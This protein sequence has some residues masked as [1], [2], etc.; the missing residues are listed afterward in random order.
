MI[1]GKGFAIARAR[2]TGLER[3]A[4]DRLPGIWPV[5]TQGLFGLAPLKP[6]K[7]IRP[8]GCDSGPGG[9]F[10]VPATSLAQQGMDLGIAVCGQVEPTMTGGRVQD[11]AFAVA[12][13][14]LRWPP[15][16]AGMR[17]ELLAAKGSLLALMLGLSLNDG[18]KSSLIGDVAA[19]AVEVGPLPVR[20]G[21]GEA[22]T[23]AEV[24]P[25]VSRGDHG[26]GGIADPGD[27]HAI[28]TATEFW[29]RERGGVA[30]RNSRVH[31]TSASTASM[32][33]PFSAAVSH[34]WVLI[35]PMLLR[36]PR[37]MT[38]APPPNA[39]N[40]GREQVWA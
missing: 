5:V 30:G 38:C 20:Q 35:Q 24:M 33:S 27:G 7:K 16:R 29:D 9:I 19:M 13:R 28:G 37:S 18:V 10:L 23:A 21:F 12:D 34:S 25:P 4:M 40:R 22:P 2:F 8:S 32:S 14:A 31:A 36:A 26:I 1:A 3:P 6:G 15:R 11:H 17:A 39:S